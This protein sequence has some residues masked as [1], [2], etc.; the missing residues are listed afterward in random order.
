MWEMRWDWVIDV[1]TTYA[2]FRAA[3]PAAVACCT[4]QS[5]RAVE[6]ITREMWKQGLVI[7]AEVVIPGQPGRPIVVYVAPR[8]ICKRAERLEGCWRRVAVEMCRRI[9]AGGGSQ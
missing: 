6:E 1:A 3:T 2:A 5:L 8:D 7:R 4:Q 9:R